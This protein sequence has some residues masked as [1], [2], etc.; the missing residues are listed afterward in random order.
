MKKEFPF[1]LKGRTAVVTGAAGRLG[2]VFAEALAENGA[3][4]V[5]SD[6]HA[7]RGTALAR[8]LSRRTG[9]TV[10]F[11]RA[12]VTDRGSVRDL[13]RFAV[14]KFKK[15]DVLVNAAMGLGKDFYGSLENYS[16]AEWDLAMKV[17]VGGTFLC[18][19]AFAPYMKKRRKGSIINLGSIYGVVAADQRIYGRSGI[20]SPAV[21]AASKG[22]VISL[23]KYCA[24][25]WAPSGIRVNAISPGGVF[26][27]QARDFVKR[28]SQRT[29]MG[30]ML[31]RNELKG[32]VVYL[33]SEA[34]SAVTGHN[35]MVDGGWTA[36]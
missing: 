4:V 12:D 22:A 7:R 26:D 14:Q 32:A 31:D 8:E 24:A 2:P 35:L 1:T 17:N 33:A 29:P 25:Y 10:L 27:G 21:Y 23:T 20:N 13:A 30:R 19:Q 18:M 9:S 5:I 6:L 36:W 28:Y 3:A 11:R 16:W 15:I 34:S